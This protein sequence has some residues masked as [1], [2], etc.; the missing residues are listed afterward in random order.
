MPG[1][2]RFL[3]W[4]LAYALLIAYA[5]TVIGP[6]GLHYVPLDP[7]KAWSEFLSRLSVWVDNGSDQRADWMGNLTMLVP[8]GF[9]TTATLAPRRGA[10]PV[11][12]LLA[13]VMSVTFVLAMKYAQLYFPPR[14]VTLNY[15]VAQTS[16]AALG[17]AVFAASHGRLM[18]MAWGRAR[19]TLRGLLILYAAGVFGFMLM[20]LDFALSSADLAARASQV[21]N[22]LFQLPGAGRPALVQAMVLIASGVAMVPFGVLMVLAPRGRNRLFGHAMVHGLGWLIAV[23]CLTA[24]LLS[25]SPTLVTLLVRIG[26]LA[27]GVRIMPWVIRQDPD[28]LRRWFGTLALWA[29]PPYL[30]VLVAVNGLASRHWLNPEEALDAAYWKGLLPLFDYYIVTKGDAAKNIVAHIVMYAP[31]GL[32]A[33]VRGFRPSA[34]LWSGLLLALIVEGS[35]FFRPGLQGDF[36]AVAVAGASA[37]LGARLMPGVWR[38]LEGVTLP[39]LA[40]TTVLGPGW[41]ERAAAARLREAAVS[42]EAGGE[43][44]RY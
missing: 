37:W 22:L 39:P 15:V 6:M 19:E 12:F 36:N 21:P 10:G 31:L 27:I 41:R 38:L 11:T 28:R 43:V 13:F 23:F 20:P 42:A 40:R 30:V 32:L 3:P 18:R 5:S 25:G 14:T 2:Q 16:G 24:L 26:G 7:D 29:L 35:R 4:L 44:D 8:L 1:Q 17:I 34:A 9:L 33:W